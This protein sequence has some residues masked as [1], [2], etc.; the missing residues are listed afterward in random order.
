MALI[1]FEGKPIE[2]LV[3]E[4]CSAV[5]RLYKPRA[6]RKEAD[7]KAY[8][9]KTIERAKAEAEVEISLIK[10]EADSEL[11]Q[12]VV[13]RI[14]GQELNRQLNIESVVEKSVKFLPSEVSSTPIDNYWKAKYFD[15]VQDISD[16]KVQETWAKILAGEVDQPGSFS[17]KTLQI[18]G[19]LSKTQAEIFNHAVSI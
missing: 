18:L 9:L 19:N 6:I 4:V 13:A 17:L 10:A 2:K 12:R 15:Y 3:E 16:E 5:G 8:E 11:L 1:K 7:A 14:N